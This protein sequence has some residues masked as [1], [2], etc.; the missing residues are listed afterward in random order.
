[1]RVIR[2]LRP[3]VVVTFDARG[4]Y[5]HPDH[6]AVHRSTVAAFEQAGNPGC[7]PE[8]AEE[9]LTPYAPKRLYANAFPRSVMA[10]MREEMRA[11][12]GEY[13]PGGDA[14]TIPFEEMGAT[15]EEITTTVELTDDEFETK[16]RAFSSHRTQIRP[17]SSV[18][19]LPRRALRE[20][21]G[22]ERFIR[23]IPPARGGEG[24]EHE[25]VL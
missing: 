12:G 14:A 24:I 15:D 9:G 11:V 18:R 13:R 8:Y 21:L 22:T 4:G 6:L 7:F 25:L 20:W 17:E 10:R 16:L 2:R 19:L 23:L 3:Q 1:V 5:G